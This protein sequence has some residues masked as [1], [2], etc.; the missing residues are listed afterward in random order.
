LWAD[1]TA[2]RSFDAAGELL[3][4]EACR[5]ADR[6]ERLDRLLRGDVGDWAQVIDVRGTVVLVIDSALSE[7]RQQQNALRQLFATLGLA[8]A[9]ASDDDGLTAFLAEL[10]SEVRD[11]PEP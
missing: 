8:K 10:S 5:V 1:L 11:S 3:V 9:E 7:A 6:L 4:G 2:A